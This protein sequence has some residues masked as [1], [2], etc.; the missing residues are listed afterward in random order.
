MLI[1]GAIKPKQEITAEDSTEAIDI[2]PWKY[3]F[4]VGAIITVLVV[5]TYFIFS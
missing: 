2:T 5:S 4:F 3:A 1:F